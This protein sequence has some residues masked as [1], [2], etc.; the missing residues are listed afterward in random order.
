[1]MLESYHKIF[2]RFN[3]DY[4]CVT[5][6]PGAIGGD[7][8][9]EFHVLTETGIDE[10]L[11]DSE[12]NYA[13]NI[14]N[15]DPETCPVSEDALIRK[16]GIEVGHCYLLGTTYSKP[17]NANITLPDGSKISGVKGC[18]G[19]GVSRLVGAIIE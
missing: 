16:R 1:M 2:Q 13:V 11:F 3:L 15:Y 19:N 6:D 8:S 7:Y 4:H 5:A 9:H 10:L 14:E 18:Y 17:L 12:S